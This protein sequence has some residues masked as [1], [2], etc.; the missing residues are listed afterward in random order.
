MKYIAYGSKQPESIKVMEGGD[1]V[2]IRMARNYQPPDPNDDQSTG[3]W[4]ET[5]QQIDPAS[6]PTVEQVAASEET[7]WNRGVDWE[8]AKAETTEERL[9]ALLTENARLLSALDIVISKLG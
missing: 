8:T 3:Q 9:N 7:W 1:T 2:H 5:Y 6:A 4:E